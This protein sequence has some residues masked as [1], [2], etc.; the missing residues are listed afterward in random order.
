MLVAGM[1]LSGCGKTEKEN[2]FV[3]ALDTTA[4]VTINVAGAFDN[5]PSLEEVALDFTEYYPNVVVNYSKVDDYNNV[6]DMLLKDNTE[7]DIFMANNTWVKTSELVKEVAV[8]LSDESLNFDLT[9]LDAGVLESAKSEDGLYRLPIYSVSSGLIVNVTLLKENGLEIPTD[10]NEFINC[11]E[12]LKAAGYTPIYGYDADG[13]T[14]LSQGLYSGMV[15]ALAAKQN[16]DDTIDKALNAGENDKKDV[17]LEALEKEEAFSRLGYYSREANES[18]TD[19]YESAILRFFEGDVP[20]LAATT[21]TMSGTAKRESKSE[22]FTA[23]P[24]EYTFIAT[25]LGE[26][27]AYVY[28]NSSSGLSI[29][30]N[31]ANVEYAEEFLRFFCTVEELN[32]SADAKGMLSTSSSASSALSFPNLKMDDPDYVAY[33]SDFYLESLQSKTINEIIRLVSDEGVSASEAL[34]SYDEIMQGYEN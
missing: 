32:V 15:M 13:K 29:N 27:G 17:Y 11:C 22:N 12:T 33:I 25:P 6:M 24:F 2:N 7:V 16:T 23:N 18:I 20:F 5:F 8:D 19:S 10:Y 1:L 30:K 26:D 3:P 9:A 28:V 21:E 31:G 4:E 14:G 34:E